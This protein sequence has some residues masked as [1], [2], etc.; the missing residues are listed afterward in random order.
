MIDRLDLHGL[1]TIRDKSQVRSLRGFAEAEIYRTDL[2]FHK[3][4]LIALTVSS[5]SSV[6]SNDLSLVLSIIFNIQ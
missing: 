6:F 3:H 1:A 2:R 4:S 5:Q